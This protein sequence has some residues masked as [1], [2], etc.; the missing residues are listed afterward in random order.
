MRRRIK[1]LILSPQIYDPPVGALE[2]ADFGNFVLNI[3]RRSRI[4]HASRVHDVEQHSHSQ[5]VMNSQVA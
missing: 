2:K 1:I 3:V 5:A 4:A